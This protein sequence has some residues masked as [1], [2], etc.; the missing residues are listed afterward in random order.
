MPRTASKRDRYGTKSLVEQA[1]KGAPE[2]VPT[3]QL[4]TTVRAAAGKEIP[5]NTVFQAAKSLVKSGAATSERDGREY[6][7]SLRQ[8]AAAPAQPSRAQ[9]ESLEMADD[10]PC[11]CNC[12]CSDEPAFPQRLAP[13]EVLVLS[14]DEK[15][16]VTLTNVH[17][18]AQIERHSVG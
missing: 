10:G 4:V 6:T 12:D 17:G 16:V 9:T 5:Y 14:H 7:F 15:T 11:D 3:R 2:G 18:K 1:L 8:T 13:G